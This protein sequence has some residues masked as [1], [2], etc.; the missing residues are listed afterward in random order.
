MNYF[1]RPRRSVPG[2][3]IA[4]EGD[5]SEIFTTFYYTS[6]LS[7]KEV[8]KYQL[9]TRY[10]DKVSQRLRLQR[11]ELLATGKEKFQATMK[12]LIMAPNPFLDLI[13]KDTAAPFS[14]P[15]V[16]PFP[17]KVSEKP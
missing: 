10:Q 4:L 14:S 7:K 8:I 6:Q 13:K 5:L 15:P 17:R 16:L 2:R 3:S 12:D 11:E 9:I 1:W